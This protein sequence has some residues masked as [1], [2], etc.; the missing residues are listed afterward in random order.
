MFPSKTIPLFDW[1][2]LMSLIQ[3][4]CFKDRHVALSTQPRRD[5][6]DHFLEFDAFG[7]LISIEGVPT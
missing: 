1:R 2:K 4:A 7:F 6:S 5:M 3:F